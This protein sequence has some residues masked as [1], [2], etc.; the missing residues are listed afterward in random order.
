MKTKIYFQPIF[1]NEDDW[2]LR[3]YSFEVYHDYDNA[4]KDFPDCQI[5]AYS[6]NDIEEPIFVDEPLKQY[7][8]LCDIGFSVQSETK[9]P[10]NAEI[11]RG[12][13]R[14]VKML[15]ENP[16]EIQEAT[17]VVDIVENE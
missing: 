13:V 17:G 6:G 3:L 12:L 15:Q 2:G 8:L 1:K 10:T 11:M 16:D 4:K 5:A 14:R 9:H 7:D